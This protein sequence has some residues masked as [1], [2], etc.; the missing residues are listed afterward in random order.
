MRRLVP[1]AAACLWFSAVLAQGPPAGQKTEEYY[2]N[3]QVL[4]GYP[5]DQLVP[6]MQF[7][8]N[9]LN[10]D[11]DHCHVERAP[12]KDDKKEKQTA[13]KMITMTLGINRD[14]FEGKREVTCF[15]CHRGTTHPL[16]TPLVPERDEPETAAAAAPAAALPA[17]EA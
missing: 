16:A 5:A 9:S 8:A 7:I 2:K 14:T 17:A 10:V 1:F 12:E 4:K 11:C 13:R 3:I 6:T 15:S